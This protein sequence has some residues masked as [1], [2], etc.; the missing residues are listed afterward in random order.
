M[1]DGN[2]WEDESQRPTFP[3][4]LTVSL[5]KSDLGEKRFLLAQGLRIRPLMAG[6]T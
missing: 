5:S 3:V 6:K 4:V 1:D 2:P